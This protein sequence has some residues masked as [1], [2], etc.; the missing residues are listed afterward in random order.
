DRINI[1]SEM[2]QALDQGKPV[3]LTNVKG[4][5]KGFLAMLVFQQT[6]NS[7]LFVMPSDKDARQRYKI[8]SRFTDLDIVYYPL[9]QVHD[10][11]SDA[12]SLTINAERL[13]AIQKVLTGKPVLVVTSMDALL[14][15][16]QNPDRIKNSFITLK[17]GEDYGL[18]NLA[19]LLAG[20]GYD[21]VYQTEARGQFSVRGG[22]V[23]VFPMTS[24]TAYRLEFFDDEIE[25]IRVLDSASQRSGAEVKEIILTPAAEILLTD[26]ERTSA[27][28]AFKQRYGSGE[29]LDRYLEL[30]EKLAAEP[31]T[32]DE[33]LSVLSERKSS[34][35]DYMRQS[36]NN[37]T[38]VWDDPTSSRETASIFLERAGDDYAAL[39]EEGEVF[40]E[41]AEKFF[42]VYQI[43]RQLKAGRLVQEYLFGTRQKKGI[44]IDMDSRAIESFAGQPSIF[45][46]FLKNRTRDG[47]YI[48]FFCRDQAGADKIRN[49]VR[50]I[51]V[52][53]V[54]EEDSGSNDPGI[55]FTIGE[56]SEGF[57]LARE[58]IVF[59]NETDYFRPEKKR[60]R[61][62]NPNARKIDH[63][64]DLKIGDYVVHDV[65]GI[66]IYHGIEQ[67]EIDGVTKDLMHIEYAG[68]ASL[69]IPVE[70]MDSIQVYIGTG[71]A[72][73]KISKMGSP[74]WVNAKKKA[75]KAVEDMAD[76]LIA[77]Y[78]RRKEAKGYKF[79]SDTPWQK[80]FEDAFPY[81]ETED[82][83]RS[84][85]EIKADMENDMPMDRLL[86][87]DVGYG[88]T[89]VAF[90]AAFKAAMEGKQTAILVPTTVLA[91]QHYNSALERFKNFPVN[92][93]VLSR[94][95]TPQEQ[96]QIL[97]DVRSGK[98]DIV[99]GTHRLL[100]KD[101]VFKDIGLLVIDEEQRFGVRS[102]EKIKQLRENI[103]VL[104][105]SA[106]PI[107]RTLHMSLSGVRDMSV[108][109][110]PPHGRRPVQTYVMNYSPAI[111]RDA[112]DRE[113]ARD[114]Q[115]Y[116]IHN[117]VH[118][119][120]ETA[121]S[122][123]Q[124]V[125]DARIVTA[126]GKMTG[127]E[128][129]HVMERFLARDFDILVA[130]T[131]VESGLDVKNANT[132]IVD[133]GDAFG[134]AQ[135]Y[136]LRGRVGRSDN[137]AYAY[138]TH[139]KQILS[140]VAQKRLKAIRDFTAFGSGFKIALRDLEI[141]GAGN[142]LGAEQSGHLAKIGYE[143]YT[144]ILEETVNRK[145]T[146]QTWQEI[147][148][149]SIHIPIDGF[150]PD[151]YISDEQ[152]KYDIYSRLSYVS[153]W[154]D[155]DSL[156]E[157]LMDRFGDIPQSVYNLMMTAMIKNAANR[158]G[159]T[160]I[161]ERNGVIRIVF[162]DEAHTPVPDA[163]QMKQIPKQWKLKLGA[164]RAGNPAWSI[165][166][167]LTGYELLKKLYEFLVMFEPA[168]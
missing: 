4:G 71:E 82:Q 44:P 132:L 28:E 104:T 23:D 139:R 36:D 155:Y 65:H 113:I 81:E 83:L 54:I 10:Y 160:E 125:P 18:E 64:T 144:R 67:M 48:H 45:E 127:H 116:F 162:A 27:I 63:F 135:L 12:H 34:F 107:P 69:Y 49:F 58:K 109:E 121:A 16:L 62:K 24:D 17:S 114:G 3:N 101:V 131:I 50:E 122:L 8:L 140:E 165:T 118:D 148:P 77:L 88:K 14:K 25:T 161:T 93:A 119:I 134:L 120:E 152:T 26:E 75:T 133:G 78:A 158:L 115:V 166:P 103:D 138:I 87:G 143:L 159:I 68:D 110:E 164:G 15:R 20:Y 102:K 108:L 21:R 137:Q 85:E 70:Q 168:S 59:L 128:L 11:F 32:H 150:I 89:E 72:K 52:G 22:I 29:K 42:S 156:E 38:V 105:L 97:K 66:G 106:T 146:G 153:D 9:E 154:N 1:T 124:L 112:I 123:H 100:S 51:G 37:M 30:F 141:R 39:I 151:G 2:F 163:D 43:E 99:I 7:V 157:E 41:E 46:E 74:D 95:K 13:T 90:R 96:K 130:T 94:F 79:A 76:E 80:D 55:R 19:A 149:V 86:C 167:G 61:K 142:L 84:I 5:L 6:E 111:I 35:I 56:I 31:G 117:K 92:I 129:E 47:F 147:K 98:V 60:R 91:Q 53:P 73:P 40:P 57:E 126:H 145:M 136:Q 33:T